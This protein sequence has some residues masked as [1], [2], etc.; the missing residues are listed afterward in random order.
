MIDWCRCGIKFLVE[1]GVIYSARPCGEDE[2][3]DITSEL[4]ALKGRWL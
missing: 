2:G 1:R 3:I 4:S